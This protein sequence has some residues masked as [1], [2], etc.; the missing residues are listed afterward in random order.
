MW[1]SLSRRLSYPSSKSKS[2]FRPI[3][4][5]SIYTF[6]NNVRRR[7]ADAIKALLRNGLIGGQSGCTWFLGV[8]GMVVVSAASRREEDAGDRLSPSW[9]SVLRSRRPAGRQP[10]DVVEST[11]W[12]LLS[13]DE[14][15]DLPPPPPPRLHSAMPRA[16]WCAYTVWLLI[17]Q[18]LLVSG[19]VETERGPG[20]G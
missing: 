8:E 4:T 5:P 10:D 9:R 15:G 1:R 16:C 6:T 11:G 7:R 13:M 19:G 2:S 14:D 3:G 18:H 20:R 12:V 17:P